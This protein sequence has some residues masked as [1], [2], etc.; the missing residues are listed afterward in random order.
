MPTFDDVKAQPHAVRTLKQA[1]A[2]D[3]VAQSYLFAGPTGV[4]KVR[5]ALA[6]ASALLCDAR[7][8][9]GCGKCEICDRIA[10]G[11]HPDVRVIRPRD[12]GDRNVEVD[13]VRA[14]IR[15]F[16]QFAPFEG[17]E[18]VLIFA[19]A[20]IAFPDNH[21]QAANALLKSIEEPR[22]HVRFVLCASQPER[23]LPTIRSRSQRVRFQRLPDLTL[24]QILEEANVI[25]KE[26][27]AAIALADGRADLALALSKEG[28]AGT[29]VDLAL[30]IDE[31]IESGRPG[32][33]AELADEVSK[34]GDLD[35]VLDTLGTLYRD[36]ACIALR[37]GDDALVLRSRAPELRARA[38]TLDATRAAA[39]CASLRAVFDDLDK[40]GNPQILLDSLWHV[41][42]AAA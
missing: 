31:V 32:A 17:R 23:L 14:E 25:A 6:L 21:V 24:G 13:Y 3:R 38:A 40:N 27:E 34:R 9:V 41:L 20:D 4:G 28:Y 8:K 5:A 42:R 15:P 30:R 11:V 22:A 10:R 37:L 26:R 18:A 39:R 35:R 36:I 19:D 2:R 1:I 29:L 33:M 16:T 12:E 7:P